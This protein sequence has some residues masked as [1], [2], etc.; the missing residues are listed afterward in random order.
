MTST[1]AA[2]D[3]DVND[4]TSN[5]I[6]DNDAN[7]ASGINGN[8]VVPFPLST[9]M[10]ASATPMTAATNKLKLAFDDLGDTLDA[11]LRIMVARDVRREYGSVME[12]DNPDR[13]QALVD[14]AV[15][16]RAKKTSSMW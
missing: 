6:S 3:D 7:D 11:T 9:S 15:R 4:T 5:Q 1:T 13:F 2:H 16:R 8:D 14:D 12:Y 10:L